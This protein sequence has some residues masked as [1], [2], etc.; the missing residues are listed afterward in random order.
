MFER[1]GFTG[2]QACEVLLTRTM[3]TPLCNIFLNRT[4][5]F[6]FESGD[7]RMLIEH[8]VLTRQWRRIIQNRSTSQRS[9][10]AAT[11]QSSASAATKHS[12]TDSALLHVSPT[13]DDDVPATPQQQRA[14]VTSENAVSATPEEEV[15]ET[16]DMNAIVTIPSTNNLRTRRQQ[17]HVSYNKECCDSQRD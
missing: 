4:K 9:S 11:L 3:T 14:A 16:V 13:E 6:V 7:H 8:P 1:D 10:T 5:L 15:K 12:I 2:F 17:V